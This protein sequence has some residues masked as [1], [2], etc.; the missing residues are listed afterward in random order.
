MQSNGRTARIER[1]T[2]ETEIDLTLDLAGPGVSAVDTGNGVLA[3]M[4]SPL[5]R[6]G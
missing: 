4:V 2:G 6:H 5:S 1:K 3:H